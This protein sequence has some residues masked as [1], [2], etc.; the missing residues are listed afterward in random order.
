MCA[1]PAVALAITSGE[2]RGGNA[3][4]IALEAAAASL[5]KTLGALSVTL[6]EAIAKTELTSDQLRIEWRRAPR[7][8]MVNVK[9]VITSNGVRKESWGRVE[10][11]ERVKVLV[12]KRALKNGQTIATGDLA[13]SRRTV[14]RNN[15]WRL[16]PSALRGSRILADVAEGSIIDDTML[17][18]PT[19][20]P[21]GHQIKIEISTGRLRV[22]TSGVLERQA[23]PGELTTIR[24][25]ENRR[26]VRVRLLS[27][28]RAKL[29]RK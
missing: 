17:E 12:A 24:L 11:G 8:G 16:L 9:F 26:T 28:T 1:F 3:E 21:R 14:K 6:P 19:P 27:A 22:A 2:A 25:T 29:V 23:R 10:I 5:P 13:L 20:L 4:A 15:G 7:A 18:A